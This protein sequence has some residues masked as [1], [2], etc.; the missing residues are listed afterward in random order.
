MKPKEISIKALKRSSENVAHK[1]MFTTIVSNFTP[2]LSEMKNEISI[3][4]NF[5][6]WR[7]TY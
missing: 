5:E 4:Q 6:T 1:E 2:E 7:E 3:K